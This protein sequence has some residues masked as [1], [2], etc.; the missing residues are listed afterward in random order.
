MGNYNREAYYRACGPV[1]SHKGGNVRP[2]SNSW[3][4]MERSGI[5]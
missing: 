5:K 2:T 4:E 3:Q 1:S